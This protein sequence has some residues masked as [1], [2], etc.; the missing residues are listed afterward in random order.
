M[1]PEVLKGKY[2]KQADVW[3]VGVIAYMLLSSQMPFYGKKRQHIVEQIMS[4][5]FEFNG[6]RWK[7]VSNQAKEFVRELLVVDPSER[8][9][10]EQALAAAWLNRRFSATVRSPSADEFEKAHQSMINYAKYSKLKQVALMVIAHRS[11][12]EEIGILRKLFQ[13]YDT[14]GRGHVT[15]EQ[16]QKTILDAGYSQDACRQIFD[17]LVSLCATNPVFCSSISLILGPSTNN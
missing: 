1:A 10:A 2:S 15:Y 17:A 8:L 6:R 9:T 12:S 7:R 4:G 5:K 3:S 13:K 11:T 14:E 16:F